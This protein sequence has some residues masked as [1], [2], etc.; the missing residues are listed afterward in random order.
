[1][2]R[3]TLKVLSGVRNLRQQLFQELSQGE[4]SAPRKARLLAELETLRKCQP[5]Q[6]GPM[7]NGEPKK[8]SEILKVTSI[9]FCILGITYNC[10]GMFG[11]GCRVVFS[12]LLQKR[13]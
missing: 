9:P 11:V 6:N 8:E 1:M 5:Y 12:D 7:I 2:E 13:L 4:K 10:F 3:K